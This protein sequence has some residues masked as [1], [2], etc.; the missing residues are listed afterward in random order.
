MPP[1]KKSSGNGMSKNQQK[2]IAQVYRAVHMQNKL[3]SNYFKAQYGAERWTTLSAALQKPYTHVALVNPFA[4]R[5]FVEN[6]LGLPE[7][8]VELFFPELFG[9]RVYVHKT[10]HCCGVGV[11]SEKGVGEEIVVADVGPVS[12]GKDSG[13]DERDI[14]DDSKWS[15]PVYFE[16][17][18]IDQ[19]VSYHHLFLQNK[20][21]ALCS[22]RT[23]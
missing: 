13:D 23:R 6:L 20:V 18:G 4:D 15:E 8:K 1:T 5:N 17:L 11:K 9:D 12:S 19:D 16:M 14:F 2:K 22:Y 7:N 10:G 21:T 3:F